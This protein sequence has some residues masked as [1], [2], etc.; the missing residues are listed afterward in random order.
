MDPSAASASVSSRN[1]VFP[2]GASQTYLMLTPPFQAGVASHVEQAS[3][4]MVM[5]ASKSSSAQVSQ[6]GRQDSSRT[7]QCRAK[8]LA[9]PLY[10]RAEI[11]K[12]QASG[13]EPYSGSLSLGRPPK[14]T[15]R[16]MGAAEPSASSSHLDRP[17]IAPRCWLALLDGF[18]PD[19]VIADKAYGTNAILAAVEAIHGG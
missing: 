13:I 17:L 5:R 6:S 4:T 11:W 15:S 12:R 1:Q 7:S 3:T 10:L 8:L 19:H 14:S 18:A 16:S 9:E 2:P